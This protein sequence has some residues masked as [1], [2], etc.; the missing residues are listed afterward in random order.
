MNQHAVRHM[1]LRHTCIPISPLA[2]VRTL[3]QKKINQ[4]SLYASINAYAKIEIVLGEEAIK[5][6]T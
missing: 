2:D 3:Y 1:L 6:G 4:K 5:R